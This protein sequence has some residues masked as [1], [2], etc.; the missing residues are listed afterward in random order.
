MQRDGQASQYPSNHSIPIKTTMYSTTSG[1]LTIHCK[2][3]NVVLGTCTCTRV[4]LEY[5]FVVLVLVLVL[6]A[7]VLVLV[8]VLEILVLVFVHVLATNAPE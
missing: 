2:S 3:R 1:L 5:K 8:L 4:V 7:L 6:A